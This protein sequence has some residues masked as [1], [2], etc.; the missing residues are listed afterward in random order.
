M[1]QLHR[2][3]EGRKS[4][5][6]FDPGRKRGGTDQ[7]CPWAA[8]DRGRGLNPGLARRV[9]SSPVLPEAPTWG[10]G[11][12]FGQSHLTP[13]PGTS[14]KGSAASQDPPPQ[15]TLSS[16]AGLLGRCWQGHPPASS[17]GSFLLPAGT[18]PGWERRVPGSNPDAGAAPAWST[19]WQSQRGLII[20]GSVATSP[21]PELPALVA[22]WLAPLE[23]QRPE[24][25]PGLAWSASLPG[26]VGVCPDTSN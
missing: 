4:W 5:V 12:T 11:A 17:L 25:P 10:S 16:P 19:G 24:C 6:P 1:T 14:D 18:C 21:E 3:G 15:P 22:P 9:A 8:G 13:R 26:T 23:A 20:P 7:F 2:W